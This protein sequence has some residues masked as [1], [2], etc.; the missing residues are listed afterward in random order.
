MTPPEPGGFSFWTGP[1]WLAIQVRGAVA[2]DAP[3]RSI[4]RANA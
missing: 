1:D 2:A 4:I 3:Y